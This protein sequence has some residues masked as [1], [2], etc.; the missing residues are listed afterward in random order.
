MADASV[1]V[2]EN[3]GTIFGRR[4][5]GRMSEESLPNLIPAP[6]F[7]AIVANLRKKAER[8]KVKL[9]AD[10]ALYI[11]Q[12]V[13]SNAR[14]LDLALIRLIAHSSLTGTA[15]TLTYTQRVLKNFIDAQAHKATV[16]PLQKLLSQQ[17]GTKEAK[18]KR[19]LTEADSMSFSAC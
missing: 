16:D 18:I 17:F 13:R 4:K 8:V 19:D 14:A 7:E 5:G 6:D 11:A 2:P 1:G 3:R 10:V 15:I 9:P 12:N